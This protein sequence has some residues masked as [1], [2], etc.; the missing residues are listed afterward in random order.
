[1]GGRNQK[2]VRGPY[3]IATKAP[4]IRELRCTRTQNAW[5][6]RQVLR[7]RYSY[8]LCHQRDGLGSLGATVCIGTTVMGTP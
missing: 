4:L 2:K 7:R 8:T 5:F 6:A 3:L 1:M